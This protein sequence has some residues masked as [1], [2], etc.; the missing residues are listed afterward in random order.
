MQDDWPLQ[1]LV[2]VGVG[3]LNELAQ[4]LEPMGAGPVYVM[5]GQGGLKPL[6]WTDEQRACLRQLCGR[7]PPGPSGRVKR[8]PSPATTMERE[9]LIERVRG[10]TGGLT[11]HGRYSTLMVRA[12][13]FELERDGCFIGPF[14][15]DGR[16]WAAASRK[17]NAVRLH[18]QRRLQRRLKDRESS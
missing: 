7:K 8:A 9:A 17:K 6:E 2:V 16:D 15:A 3:I 11:P 13:V 18:Q 5:D 1:R 4:A 14:G 12:L 10:L